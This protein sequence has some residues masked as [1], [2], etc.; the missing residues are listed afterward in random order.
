MHA[1]KHIRIKTCLF[2]II[3]HHNHTAWP[4]MTTT[5][6]LVVAPGLVA[7]TP[8]FLILPF[9]SFP[10]TSTGAFNPL[11]FNLTLSPSKFTLKRYAIEPQTQGNLTTF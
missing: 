10:E 1:C 9:L 4:L 2:L 7:R 6:A 3:I 5:R 11:I 8:S